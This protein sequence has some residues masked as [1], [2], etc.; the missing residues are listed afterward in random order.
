M[1]IIVLKTQRFT[2]FKHSNISFFFVDK[3]T[4]MTVLCLMKRVV[5]TVPFANADNATMRDGDP[6]HGGLTKCETGELMIQKDH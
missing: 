4:T 3:P 5:A 6:H 1:K 2:T